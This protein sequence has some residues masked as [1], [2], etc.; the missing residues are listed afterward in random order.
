MTMD[1]KL[2]EALLSGLYEEAD[3]LIARLDAVAKRVDHQEGKLLQA[4]NVL[5]NAAA[6]LQQTM[7]ES[8]NMNR[9]LAGQIVSAELAKVNENL[10][11]VIQAN[12][13]T[14]GQEAQRA[15]AKELQKLNLSQNLSDLLNRRQTK[16]LL[17]IFAAFVFCNALTVTSLLLL[18]PRK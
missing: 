15:V 9:E 16:D 18:I 5:S 12:S 17:M 8:A 3:S 10:S 4:A 13:E 14:F 11:R 6:T 2:R 1:T 7:Q